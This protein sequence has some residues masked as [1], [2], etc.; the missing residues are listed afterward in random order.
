MDYSHRQAAVRA[1]LEKIRLE[2]LLIT[3]LPNIRYLCGFTGS[4]GVLV[5]HR[6]RAAF[7]TD[8]RYTAQAREEV[9]D[10]RVVIAKASPLLAAA[11]FAQ[12]SRLRTL[13]IESDHVTVRSRAAL[14]R[15]LGGKA[16]LRDTA[17]VVETF[18]VVKDADEIALIR[19]A[20]NLGARLLDT[21]I[22]AIRPGVRECD[23]AAELEYA[24]RRAGAQAMSFE[25]IV[26]AGPRSAM[27]HGVASAAPIPARGF[28]ILDFGVILQGYCSDMT[29]TV[30]LG[31]VSVGERSMYQ[32]VRDAQQAA[33]DAVRA[34]VVCGQVD[35]AA[36]QVLRRAGFA[37]Y[38]THSTGHGVGLEI[39]ELP[40]LGRGQAEALHAGMVV[41]VEPGVYVAGQGGVRIE[42]MI[43][44]TEGGC[45]VLT[46]A[47]KE[48]IE[49]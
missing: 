28:V 1:Q 27:P 47:P 13:G 9:A 36:R 10:A 7:F 46:P 25:T 14:R 2:A 42:D 37:R 22:Q 3:H 8:G 34:G 21:A 49:L 19:E 40:R 44:V 18:R 41:T 23:V 15:A 48:L 32:A 39:H 35:G 5:I 31:K 16:R 45:D 12:K 24:A 43:V 20:V 30:H 38:F 33:V 6:G 26:A 17:S 29:R 11:Q 4:S